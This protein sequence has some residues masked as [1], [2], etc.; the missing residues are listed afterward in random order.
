LLLTTASFSRE[1]MREAYREGVAPV[2][3]IDG[4]MLADM[5]RD[6]ELGVVSHTSTMEH[7]DVDEEYFEML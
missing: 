2:D 7:I 3:L 1:A 5:L 4:H 6:L